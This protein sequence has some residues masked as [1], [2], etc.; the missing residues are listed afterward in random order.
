MD[1]KDNNQSNPKSSYYSA[2]QKDYFRYL[3]QEGVRKGIH[4][5]PD[6]YQTLSKFINSPAGQR[7]FEQFCS[8]NP[9]RF[10]ISLPKTSNPFKRA[11]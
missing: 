9:S 1:Y 7:G 2:A 10:G 4:K 6:F 5:H 3:Y 8:I 11:F